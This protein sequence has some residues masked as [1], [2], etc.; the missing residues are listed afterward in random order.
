M[1]I[2]FGVGALNFSITILLNQGFIENSWINI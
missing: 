1:V 2:V